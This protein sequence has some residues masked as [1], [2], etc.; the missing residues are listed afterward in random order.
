MAKKRKPKAKPPRAPKPQ[1]GALAH[2]GGSV[3]PLRKGIHAEAE[4]KRM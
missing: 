2:S 4:G 3:T 1:Q